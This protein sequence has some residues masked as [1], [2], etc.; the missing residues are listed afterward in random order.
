MADR[1]YLAVHKPYNRDFTQEEKDQAS[2]LGV[3]LIK[4][5][6]HKECSIISSSPVQSPL[7]SHKLKLID[8]LGYLPCIMCNTLFQ[9]KGMRSQ[10][11][12]SSIVNAI[13]EKK[14][15]RYWLEGLSEQR[16]EDRNYIYDRRHIC[17]DC[18][19]AFSGLINEKS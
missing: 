12:R 11:E 9:N 5:G 1:C 14:P 7:L 6:A 13:N 15:F 3:G 17:A 16:E 18:V 19:Q 10:G 8:K 4:I 2:K